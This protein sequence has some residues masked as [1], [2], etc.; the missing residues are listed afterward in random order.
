MLPV[1]VIVQGMRNKPEVAAVASPQPDPESK[2]APESEP[3]RETK[4]KPEPEPPPAQINRV[5]EPKPIRVLTDAEMQAVTDSVPTFV[6]EEK[7]PVIR[8]LK[9]ALGGTDLTVKT[10]PAANLR[11]LKCKQA[12]VVEFKNSSGGTI[13]SYFQGARNDGGSVTAIRSDS[14]FLVLQAL[15]GG[16]KSASTW[17]AIWD[18]CKREKLRTF[19]SGGVELAFDVRQTGPDIILMFTDQGSHRQERAIPTSG[20]RR[21]RPTVPTTWRRPDNRPFIRG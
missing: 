17:N 3:E 2:P 6:A 11:T 4:L 14:S 15:K 20:R 9:R 19:T 12:W 7:I 5:P 10:I 13:L 8:R 21:T 18:R 1:L 16:S